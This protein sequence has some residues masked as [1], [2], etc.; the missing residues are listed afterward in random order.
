[1]RVIFIKQATD[2]AALA[3]QLVPAGGDPAQALATL[4]RANPHL[5]FQKLGDGAVVL[6][7]QQPGLKAADGQNGSISGDAFAALQAQ[8]EDEVAATTADARAGWAELQAEQREVAVALKNLAN[9][10]G[11]DPDLQAQAKAAMDAAKNDAANAKTADASLKNLEDQVN[12]ELA[13]LARLLGRT[14]ATTPLKG[15]TKGSA[16]SRTRAAAKGAAKD[17]SGGDQPG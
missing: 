2:W 1:M 17:P 7:P 5:D 8:F 11:P 12:G 14:G 16:A 9:V 3:P 15:S 10:I 6:V 13:A 4:Q